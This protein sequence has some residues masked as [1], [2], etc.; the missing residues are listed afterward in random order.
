MSDEKWCIDTELATRFPVY[1]R[2]NANDVLPDP[3]TPL[4]ASLLWNPEMFPGGSL[5]YVELGSATAEEAMDNE[6]WPFG[7]FCYGYLYVNVTM[8][9]LVGIRSGIGWE[10]IDAAFFGSH[11]DA[12]T[13]RDSPTDINAELTQKIAD[14]T[15][16]TLTTSTFPELDE[17]TRIADDLRANRPDL[18]TLTNAALVAYARSMQ[19]Y[20]RL[21]WRGEVV[22]GSQA[23]VGPAVV[24]S[25]LGPDNPV[26]VVDI[27]GPAGDVVSAMPSYALWDMSRTVR[28]SAPLTKAFNDGI[29]GLHARLHDSH[30]D[31]FQQFAAFIREF[32]Y[33]GPSEW[34][35]GADSWET[36]PE[37]AL[38]LLDRMRQLDDA[39]SPAARRAESAERSERAYAQVAASLAG[40]DE[41]LATLRMGV[42]SARRF[43]GWRELAKSN[44]IKVVNEARVAL[45]EFGR[46]LAA[47]GHLADAGQIFM[48]LDQELDK[49]VY[50]PSKLTE[51]LMERER[52]WKALF[53]VEIPLFLEAG[54]PLIP[55]S[56]LPRKSEVTYAQAGSGDVLT[57]TPAA[58][59]VA[60]GRARIVL[61][62]SQIAEFEPGD[63]LVAPQTDPSWTPLFVVA[64][65]V[66]VGVGAL[67]SHAMIVSR[68]LGIPCVVAIEGI[69]AKIADGAMIE[70]DGS[71]GAVT[72]L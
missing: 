50:D 60:R 26:N 49:L 40:N 33:R 22:A 17:E 36:K 68:E 55:L 20:Q 32:G 61:D 34:D 9:R 1:T 6:G 53:D 12:P 30:P 13:H 65:A 19:P 69:T 41:A 51:V 24:M 42:D 48:A 3:I 18:S 2:F 4:G 54:K 71:T 10:G 5:A 52:E 67:S 66:V 27:T 56:Q 11:P 28:S 45:L 35:M 62:P 39:G 21:T 31:F 25:L 23:A 7:A 59:G 37:L 70:V 58:S 47:Q 63:V 14:R 64:S 16:W 43:A 29:D 38:A 72:V 46:R 8:A 57:G 15:T 44:C